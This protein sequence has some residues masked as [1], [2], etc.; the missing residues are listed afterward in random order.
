MKK[1]SDSRGDRRGKWGRSSTTMGD[2]KEG[3]IRNEL[4]MSR[5]GG[6]SVEGLVPI[7]ERRK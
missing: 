6:S 2:G 4:S 1:V 7:E 3:R 5:L